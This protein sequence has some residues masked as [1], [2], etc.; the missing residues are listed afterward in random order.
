MKFNK[1]YALEGTITGLFRCET[2]KSCESTAYPQLE[3]TAEGIIGDKHIGTFCASGVRETGIYKKGTLIRNNRQ[4]S[5][6]SEEELSDISEKMQL[7]NLKA[8]WLG[9]N[10]VIK[11]IPNFSKLPPLSIIIIRP[12]DSDFV[13]LINY[14]ENEPCT[15]IHRKVIELVGSEP[16]VG[17]IAAA[18]GRRGLVGWVERG[19][20]VHVGDKVKVLIPS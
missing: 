19:G 8:E 18:Y 3:F 10:I 7:P 11:G 6:I 15:V 13:S 14:N 5:A 12:D 1:K 20:M 17:F 2:P 9:T 4:W 16:S